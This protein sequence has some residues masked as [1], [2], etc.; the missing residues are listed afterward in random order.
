MN[1][2]NIINIAI[3]SFFNAMGE[4]NI[5]LLVINKMINLVIKVI[6]KDVSLSWCCGPNEFTD[7]KNFVINITI[8]NHQ[9][10]NF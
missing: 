2:D 7:I 3:N 4:K 6:C 10:C 5:K 1:H 8:Q 9:R